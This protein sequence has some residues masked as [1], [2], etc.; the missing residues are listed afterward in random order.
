MII[1]DIEQLRDVPVGTEVEYRQKIKVVKSNKREAFPCGGC[2]FYWECWEKC[3]ACEAC[4]RPDRTEVK[5][6]RI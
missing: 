4:E 2:I 3:P 6:I 5:F 1:T